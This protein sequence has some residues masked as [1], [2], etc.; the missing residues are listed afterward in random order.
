M[1]VAEFAELV[2]NTLPFA[3]NAQQIK[4]IDALA[5]FASVSSNVSGEDRVFILNGYAGTGKTSVVAALV[6]ALAAVHRP[7]VL[8]APTGRAAKV[9]SS[10]AHTPAYTIHRRIYRPPAPGVPAVAAVRANTSPP[11]TVFLVDEASMISGND[12]L[13]DLLQYVYSVQ[14]SKLIFIG[15]TAQLPPV[16][17]DESPAMQPETFRNMG[18]R[19]TRVTITATQRQAAGSGILYNATMLR[20][21]MAAG[22][23]P[24][25]PP[26]KLEGWN[27]VRVTDSMEF[28]DDLAA[29]YGRNSV[30]DVILITRSNS[31]A[32]NFNRQIRSQVLGYEETLVTGEP[33]LITRNDYYWAGRAKSARKAEDAAEGGY[34]KNDESAGGEGNGR[35]DFI[36]NGD[37]AVVES[38][39]GAERFGAL[40]YADVT[41]YFP[42]REAY[43]DCKILLSTLDSEYADLSPEQYAEQRRLLGDDF[44]ALRNN[45]YFNAL[46][47]KYAYAVTCHKAQGGQWPEVFVD[48]GYIPPD[49]LSDIV[50]YRWLYTAV[51][52]ARTRL[53]IVT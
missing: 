11:G 32:V 45:P 30:T 5:R 42:D 25:V 23:L 20:R 35:I 2:R 15:D 49:A 26:L 28:G 17:C 47:V 22:E 37:I 18:F 50:F 24:A 9:F 4:L 3:P 13:I 12:L 31:R 39:N 27:D 10:M 6:T 36:A 53:T 16:G 41:L 21:A 43:I 44:V 46:H 29:A 7:A 52:R 40:R 1:T 19:V 34:A 8:L 48:M 33:L 51:T 14:Y 38:I